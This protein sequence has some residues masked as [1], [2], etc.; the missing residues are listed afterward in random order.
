[1]LTE[2]DY[3]DLELTT[4][5]QEVGMSIKNV[6]A[7]S[8]RGATKWYSNVT[9]YEAQ[10]WLREEKGIAVFVTYDKNTSK[11]FATVI[12]MDSLETTNM[13]RCD[14]YEEALSEGILDAVEILTNNKN[15]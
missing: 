5:L 14:L 6:V 9:L 8:P 10:K 12:N 13:A 3:C 1:M 15:E 2:K 4:I 11:W 7:T